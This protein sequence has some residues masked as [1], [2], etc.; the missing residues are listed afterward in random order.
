MSRAGRRKMRSAAALAVAVGALIGGAGTAQAYDGNT[1]EQHFNPWSTKVEQFTIET[2]TVGKVDF[3][4]ILHL[5]GA[6]QGSAVVCWEDGYNA[7]PD[8]A[9]VVGRVFA[10]SW[11][12]VE[13]KAR[14]TFF[15]YGNRTTTTNWTLSGSHADSRRVTV[16]SPT[17]ADDAGC[18]S[19]RIELYSDGILRHRSFHVQDDAH[20]T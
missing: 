9:R 13:V 10:D 4:D 1:C 15:L 5:G 2:G 3:G 14:V 17:G 11:S 6:P 19:V 18:Y 8:R 20:Y 12:T 7:E 16:G